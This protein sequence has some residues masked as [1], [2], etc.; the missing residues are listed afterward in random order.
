MFLFIIDDG[1]LL[2][3]VINGD[4]VESEFIFLIGIKLMYRN[5][6]ELNII[7][8]FVY[9]NLNGLNFEVFFKVYLICVKCYFYFLGFY[10]W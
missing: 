5:F 3:W 9:F 8:E 10:C 2:C 1:W 6:G 4:D 7:G